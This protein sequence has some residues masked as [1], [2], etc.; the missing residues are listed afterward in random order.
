MQL[1][2]LNKIN[3][4]GAVASVRQLGPPPPPPPHNVLARL[5]GLGRYIE[6]FQNKKFC[7]KN[8][9]VHINKNSLASGGKAPKF[10][11][12]YTICNYS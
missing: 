2:I 11:Y 4:I 9:L 1:F 5:V 7:N 3:I 10:L 6:S 12:V 8:T